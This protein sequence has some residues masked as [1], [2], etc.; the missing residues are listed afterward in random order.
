MLVVSL[1]ELGPLVVLGV[2]LGLL[3]GIAVRSPD[4]ARPRP[5]L[6]HRHRLDLRLH[7]RQALLE[8]ALLCSCFSW[9]PRCWSGYGS[10]RAYL[11]RVLRVGER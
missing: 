3:L 8:I 10:R 2:V 11:G 5:R 6:L 1:I 4:R 7:S 9:P